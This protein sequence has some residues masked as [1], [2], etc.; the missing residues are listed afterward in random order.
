MLGREANID[1]CH[2]F[3][4]PLGSRHK[5]PAFEH[6]ALRIRRQTKTKDIYSEVTCIH[7]VWNFKK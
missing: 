6:A 4:G 3:E 1:C 7:M 2:V 5:C